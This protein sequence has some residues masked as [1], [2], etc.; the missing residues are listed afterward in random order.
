MRHL[1]ARGRMFSG[2]AGGAGLPI[3]LGATGPGGGFRG[4]H[5][6]RAKRGPWSSELQGGL[7][8]WGGGCGSGRGGTLFVCLSVHGVRVGRG[9]L[10]G[11]SLGRGTG[12]DRRSSFRFR[13]VGG[14]TGGRYRAGG[15]VPLACRVVF[16]AVG[17][18]CG[19]GNAA[20]KD[21]FEVSLFAAGWIGT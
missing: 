5:E 7:K 3:R 19:R 6:S 10:V 15:R 8:T 21:C 16:G 13:G 11:G 20:V 9:K 17:P 2:G 14:G 4:T 18:M 1:P 12:G